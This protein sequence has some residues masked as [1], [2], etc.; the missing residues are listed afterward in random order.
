MAKSDLPNNHASFNKGRWTTALIVASLIHTAIGLFF[1][2]WPATPNPAAVKKIKVVAV[3]GGVVLF[4]IAYWLI[5]GCRI[6]T[7][8]LMEVKLREHG[9]RR[10]GA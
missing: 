8:P 10:S 3:C 4:S 9:I 5:W 1:S 6:Y 2:F 7:G